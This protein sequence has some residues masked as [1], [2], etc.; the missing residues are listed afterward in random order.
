M[1]CKG[2]CNRYGFIVLVYVVLGVGYLALGNTAGGYTPS[3]LIGVLQ[4]FAIIHIPSVLFCY[5]NRKYIFGTKEIIFDVSSRTETTKYYGGRTETKT[6]T[7]TNYE[8]WSIRK[9]MISVS[10][11]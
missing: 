1:G 2:N 9:I 7:N 11:N 6:Y 4:A 10:R 8:R 5:F 3:G